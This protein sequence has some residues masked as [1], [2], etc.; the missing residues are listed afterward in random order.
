MPSVALWLRPGVVVGR[1]AGRG[2]Q[3]R[4]KLAS[5]GAAFL[6]V[7]HAAFELDALVDAATLNLYTT[8]L[9]EFH[10]VASPGHYVPLSLVH[11]RNNEARVAMAPPREGELPSLEATVP[12]SSLSLSPTKPPS[13]ADDLDLGDTTMR[14]LKKGTTPFAP[15]A[16]GASTLSVTLPKP[17][18]IL[19]LSEKAT[20]GPRL[21]VL[22]QLPPPG[23]V[24]VGW[25]PRERVLKE[26]VAPIPHDPIPPG[27]GVPPRLPLDREP[28]E[29]WVCDRVMPLAAGSGDERRRIGILRAGAPFVVRERGEPWSRIEI[30][31]AL[32]ESGGVGFFTTL[33]QSSCRVA[34][35]EGR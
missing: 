20:K 16:D 9:I 6:H 32:E 3:A 23:A 2:G 1:L 4:V 18:A 35:P 24:L 29:R 26:V 21:R 14:S 28:T 30:P 19:S 5:D 22:L 27:M 31:D 8:R 13:V 17:A 34:V 33:R 25:V 7:D 15:T 12:C 10:G 11:V